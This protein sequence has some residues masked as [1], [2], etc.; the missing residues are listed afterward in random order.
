MDNRLIDVAIGLALLFALTSLLTTAMQEAWSQLKGKRAAFLQRA[1]TSFVADDPHFAAALMKHPLLVSLAEGTKDA[2]GKPSYIE[3][4]SLVPA[5]LGHLVAQHASGAR[6]ASPQ[7]LISLLQ[8]APAGAVPAEFINGLAALSHGVENDWAAFEVRLAGWW[9]A[10][11]V[12]AGGWFKR[13]VQATVFGFGVLA[14]V[15][16]NINPITVASRLWQDHGL[17]AAIVSYA[18]G[19]QVQ[20]ARQLAT[21]PAPAHAPLPAA[22]PATRL[23][24]LS[25][26]LQ[27]AVQ[28]VPAAASA[29]AQAALERTLERVLNFK[30]MLQSLDARLWG[31]LLPS[32]RQL[33]DDL[34]AHSLPA[35]VRL[36]QDQLVDALGAVPGSAPAA[37]VASAASAAASAPQGCARFEPELQAVCQRAKGLDELQRLGMPIGWSESALPRFFELQH[38]EGG[39]CPSQP[40]WWANWAV[41]VLGW[42]IV[43]LACTLG[44]PFWFDTL[45]RLVNLRAAG[46]RPA[47]VAAD[48]GASAAPAR[49][50]GSGS[51]AMHDALSD[52]E[53]ELTE[54]QVRRLQRDGL[55]MADGDCSG[56]FDGKTRAR[57]RAWQERQAPGGGSGILGMA[58]IDALLGR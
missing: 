31:Q 10:V 47:T 49:V 56:W 11:S 40:A 26:A 38:C 12:R 50:T 3:A 28:A 55:Q 6:P 57:I 18:S 14:A 46:A 32:A 44:S 4:T 43:G 51:A 23:A 16:M 13:D 2:P 1:L 52:A 58:E 34:P 9:E 8:Q 21:P 41:G 33:L 5:L 35:P 30:R 53:R 15:V 39:L 29:P 27:A 20:Q 36:A 42:L 48:A 22:D 45:G 54:A 37:P 17:R 7:A 19:E 24:A 25:T